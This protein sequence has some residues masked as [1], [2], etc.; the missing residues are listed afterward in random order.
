M[1][2]K[3]RPNLRHLSRY[4]IVAFLVILSAYFSYRTGGLF[5]TSNNI[6]NV[7][8]QIAVNTILAVGLTFVIITAGID[9]SVGSVL[10]LAGVISMTFLRDGLPITGV[11]PILLA[12]PLS[13]VVA[14]FIGA[15]CGA[16][17][18][19][20][21][22]RFRMAPFVA[23][24]A[25]MTIARGLAYVYTDGAPVSRSRPPSASSARPR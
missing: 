18:G 2:P 13:A 25:M 1:K 9:L 8:R 22:T 20:F 15:G 24:L 17:N 4:G 21:V 14:S 19:F 10:A 23:T 5:I 3:R 16:F 7:S 6:A 12:I 11:L